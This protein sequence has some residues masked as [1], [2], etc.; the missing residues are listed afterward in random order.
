M[1][2]GRFMYDEA[3]ALQIVDQ[4]IREFLGHDL[5]RVVYTLAADRLHVRLPRHVGEK[6]ASTFGRN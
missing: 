1:I 4:S 2:A 5:V 6:T 3:G